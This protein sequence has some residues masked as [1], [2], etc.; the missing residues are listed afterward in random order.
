ML[1]K[2]IAQLRS[3]GE[4]GT[5]DLE[6]SD[7][8]AESHFSYVNSVIQSFLIPEKVCDLKTCNHRIR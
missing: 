6:I 5:V 7:L 2:K 8:G 4:Y 1:N 3:K